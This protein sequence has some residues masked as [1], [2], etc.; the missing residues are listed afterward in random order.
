MAEDTHQCE[1]GAPS[2][3]DDLSLPGSAGQAKSTSAYRITTHRE[4]PG[5]L[6]GCQTS[7]FSESTSATRAYNELLL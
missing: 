1:Y 2:A 7:D 6:K 3:R 5:Y 4:G